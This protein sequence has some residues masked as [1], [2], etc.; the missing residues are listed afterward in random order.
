MYDTPLIYPLTFILEVPTTFAD[1]VEAWIV[2][3]AVRAF[4]VII[5]VVVPSVTFRVDALMLA[6]AFKLLTFSL[7]FPSS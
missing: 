3:R 2:L 4:V 5:E 6:E 7:L 1:I